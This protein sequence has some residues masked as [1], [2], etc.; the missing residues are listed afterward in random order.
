M[1]MVPWFPL[2][3]VEHIFDPE[4]RFAANFI[5]AVDIYQ[6]DDAVIVETPLAGVDP[7]KVD[8]AIENDVLTIRG[9]AEARTEAK[10]TEYYRR[11][12]RTGEFVR[13]VE[14]PVSVQADRAT[15]GSKNG[16]LRITI[17]KAEHVKPKS[18]RVSVEKE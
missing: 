5:P 16:M 7:E 9:R 1:R 15:A 13:S 17:P 8:I 2:G 11:E 12:I 18:I 14:L 6:T 4:L 10:E 3:G